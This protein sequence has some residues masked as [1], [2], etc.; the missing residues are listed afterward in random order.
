M[1]LYRSNG[2]TA[3]TIP[4]ENDSVNIDALIE[5]EYDDSPVTDGTVIIN[6]ASA[7]HIAAGVWR[8]TDTKSSV[9]SVPLSYNSFLYKKNYWNY[10]IQNLI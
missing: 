7:S 1:F 3:L 8:V 2:S 10:L 6:G 9:Q 5:Y 4:P